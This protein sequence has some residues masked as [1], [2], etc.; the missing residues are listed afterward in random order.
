MLFLFV[1]L[2]AVSGVV[3]AQYESVYACSDENAL[4][5]YLRGVVSMNDRNAWID[6]CLNPSQLL[7]GRC[8]EKRPFRYKVDVVEC[9]L[10][11]F[12]GACLRPLGYDSTSRYV[13]TMTQSTYEP[14]QTTTT[15]PAPEPTTDAP[16]DAGNRTMPLVL[17]INQGYVCVDYDGGFNPN[18]MGEVTLN[19]RRVWLD[20]CLNPSELQEGT[21]EPRKRSHYRASVVECEHGC[22][23][24]RCLQ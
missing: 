8:D 16:S 11:C 13:S 18:R 10:G 22:F 6:N 12:E 21:C 9:D 5:T 7:K 23:E 1:S 24:G 14:F 19:G 3:S 4:D 15:V 17:V 2:L 20:T